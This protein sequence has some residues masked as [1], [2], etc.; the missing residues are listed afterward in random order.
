MNRPIRGHYSRLICDNYMPLCCEINTYEKMFC[1]SFFF[2]TKSFFDYLFHSFYLTYKNKALILTQNANLL[3]VRF[4]P[5][6]SS[7]TLGTHN[8]G[9]D[10]ATVFGVKPY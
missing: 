5:I 8:P 1:F 3:P 7:L 2:L 6:L 4:S 9:A 10:W